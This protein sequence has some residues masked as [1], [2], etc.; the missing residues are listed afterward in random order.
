MV[1][2][3]IAWCSCVHAQSG[4]ETQ[5]VVRG[6]GP[7]AS[8]P[9]LRP[10]RWKNEGEQTTQQPQSPPPARQ[11]YGL[12]GLN[13]FRWT[14]QDSKDTQTP[15]TPPTKSVNAFPP[16]DDSAVIAT[17]GPEQPG[18]VLSAS[19]E[20]LASKFRI[21]SSSAYERAPINW[22]PASATVPPQQAASGQGTNPLAWSNSAPTTSQELKPP[23]LSVVSERIDEARTAVQ[24]PWQWSNDPRGKETPEPLTPPEEPSFSEAVHDALS[25]AEEPSEEEATEIA[26]GIPPADATVE[27][28]IEW[29]KQTYPW[30]RPFYWADEAKY[31]VPFED[32]SGASDPDAPAVPLWAKP[33][34]WTDREQAPVR[35]AKPL[36]APDAARGTRTVAF[37]QDD[38]TLP[39]PLPDLNSPG[40]ASSENIAQGEELDEDGT[41]GDFDE[42]EKGALAEAETLG[43][44]P[45]DNSLQFLRADTVLLKP[46]QFQYDYGL[47]YSK[48]EITLPLLVT[49]DPNTVGLEHADFSI[50]EMQ[51]PLEV[52]YGLTRRIQLFLN[53]PF[54]WANTELSFTDFDLTDNDGGLGDIVFGG[55]F[56]LREGDHENS[57]A[58]LTLATV[59]PTGNSPFTPAGPAPVSPTLGGG[60]W[61]M[62]SN[63]LFVR[64]YDPVVVF[65]GFGTRQH[66]LS[67]FDGM[68]FRPGGEYNYQFGVG[69]GVNDR[70]T[71]S[72]RFNGAYVSEIHLDGQRVQGT[73]QEPMTLGLAMT[74]SKCK[75]LVEPFVDFGLTD[76]AVDARFGITWTR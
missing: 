59:A 29:E 45:V 13:I 72:T 8:K 5:A 60:T 31:E 26:R 61:S 44:E 11:G 18:S 38:D 47:T 64:N 48:F 42:D 17:D 30:I 34:K 76:D 41:S 50:R 32:E 21:A 14:N 4:G 10:F 9:W 68:N 57:D 19:G 55:S 15:A 71:F 37:Q 75:R 46:G 24:E 27:E 25:W 16:S 62:S 35:P 52:R 12:S 22:P 2:A 20:E 54:G 43:R 49:I 36:I 56:L 51:V 70:V 40:E 6:Q 53:V 39:R 33:F 63:L 66:F 58:I 28:M 65:Y 74:V 7:L 23:K 1:L 69:F 67:T 3:S 73:T